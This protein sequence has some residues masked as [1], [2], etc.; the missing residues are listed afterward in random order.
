MSKDR[1]EFIFQSA[2]GALALGIGGAAGAMA[3]PVNYFLGQAKR[4]LMEADDRDKLAE[5]IETYE[6][7]I[8][9]APDNY[10]AL[11]S[12]GRYWGLMGMGY[13]EEVEEKE[14]CYVTAR[15]YCE[16]GLRTNPEFDELVAG[17]EKIW[18]A[19]RATTRREIAT[20][21]YWNTTRAGIWK[22]CMN[23][24]EQ[25]FGLDL[26][27]ATKK[28]NAR[29]IEIDPEWAGGHPYYSWAIFYSVLPRVLGGD[30]KK[31][32]HYFDKTIEAGPNWLYIKHGR[33]VY[34][35]TKKKDRSAFIDDL[36]WVLDQDP[37]T[38]DSPFPANVWFQRTAEEM[39][40]NVEDYF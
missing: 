40:G 17:G 29:M 12:L 9:F 35:H 26:L 25:I 21:F 18:D 10:E 11:W 6:Q 34:F 1:R 7:V 23:P 4:Q 31:A 8:D 37:K 14:R 36:E 24:V 22:E 3:D 15:D 33:A 19:C 32:E 20:L 13:A 2:A 27:P 16:R 39:L 5:L 30:L 28:I 38:A